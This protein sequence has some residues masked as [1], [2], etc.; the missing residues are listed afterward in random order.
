[1]VHVPNQIVDYMNTLID[2][3]VA[4]FRV[5]ACNHMWPRDLGLIYGDLKNLN[6]TYFEKGSKPFI[7]Q[8]VIDRTEYCMI[9]FIITLR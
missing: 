5:D 7:Y 9:K 8:E 1:M 4:G 3:G 2:I 6:D